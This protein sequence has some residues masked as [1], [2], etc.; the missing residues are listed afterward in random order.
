MSNLLK[1]NVKN[2][3]ILESDLAMLEWCDSDMMEAGVEDGTG[4][5]DAAAARP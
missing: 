1:K 5:E 4:C 2:L 3:K